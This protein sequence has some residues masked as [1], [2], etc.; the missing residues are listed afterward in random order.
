MT[1]PRPLRWL[2]D[3]LSSFWLSCTLL[4]LLALLTWLGT[5]EQVSNGL[6]EVQRKYFESLFLV[7]RV[8]PVSIPLPGATLVMAVLFLNLIL[9]GIVRIR[10]GASTLGILV[11]HVGILMLLLAGWVKAYSSEDGHVTLF[12][13][14]SANTFQSYNRWELA[15]LQPLEDGKLRE[16]VAPQEDFERLAGASPVTLRSAELPFTVELT[17]FTPN[18]RVLP[19]GPMV[20]AQLPVVEGYFVDALPVEKEIENNVAA[21]YAA[22]VEREG[23]AR[24]ESI[25]YGLSRQPW[26]VTVGGREYGLELRREHY[27]MPFTVELDDFEKQDYPRLDMPKS[28]SSAVTIAEAGTRRQVTISM[29]E[30]LRQEGLV[31]YQASWGPSNARPGDPLFST[32]AVVRNPADRYPLYACIVIATGLVLHFA[33]RLVRHVRSQTPRTA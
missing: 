28:F 23:G 2:L 4:L 33:R 14:Q 31:L 22:L 3:A 12:E 11:T 15:I 24:H 10:K 21:V 5:L 9:G 6:F 17:R 7:H 20:K 18:A 25:L 27:P 29:N 8:G 1:A 16:T 32:L 26:T 30:P 19:K 13:G